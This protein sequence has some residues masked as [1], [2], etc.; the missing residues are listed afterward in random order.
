MNNLKEK[1]E[2]WPLIPGCVTD[3]KCFWQLVVARGAIRAAVF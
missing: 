1:K 3:F 2:E